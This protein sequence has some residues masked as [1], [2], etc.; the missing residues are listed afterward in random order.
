MLKIRLT[1]LPDEVDSF[2]SIL[3]KLFCVTDESK[4]YKN[5][6]SKYVRKYFDVEKRGNDNE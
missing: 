2:L 4:S 5:S 6:N 3:R 1:G